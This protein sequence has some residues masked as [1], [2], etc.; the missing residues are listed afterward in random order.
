MLSKYDSYQVLVF[1]FLTGRSRLNTKRNRSGGPQK[2][3]EIP[4]LAG[5]RSLRSN[6]GISCRTPKYTEVLKS[7]CKN[8]T[9]NN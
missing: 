4:K 8:L 3:Q 1:Y 9:A 7:V 5:R 6:S 2:N